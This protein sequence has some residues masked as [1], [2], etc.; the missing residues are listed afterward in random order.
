M[1]EP[2]KALAFFLTS[3]WRMSY[4]PEHSREQCVKELCNVY[5]SLGT[6][7]QWVFVTLNNSLFFLKGRTEAKRF[8]TGKTKLPCFCSPSSHALWLPRLCALFGSFNYLIF[9]AVLF[10]P[11]DTLISNRSLADFVWHCNEPEILSKGMKWPKAVNYA[12]MCSIGHTVWA[13]CF[14]L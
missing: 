5:H 14:Y 4:Y 3:A 7:T 10:K 2:F 6:D 9:T 11:C 1:T 12:F 8:L 13:L